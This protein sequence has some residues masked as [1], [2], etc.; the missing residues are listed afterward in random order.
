MYNA[1]QSYSHNDIDVEI[2][3]D[4]LS[5]WPKLFYLK[6]NKR[7]N[8]ISPT[9]D[10]K[11]FF[12][13][14]DMD[15]NELTEAIKTNLLNS[16]FLIVIISPSYLNS[17]W[18]RLE[19]EYFLEKEHNKKE[20]IFKIIK[21]PSQEPLPENLIGQLEYR[22]HNS[23]DDVSLEYYP[24]EQKYNVVLNQLAHKLVSLFSN[25]QSKDD[26]VLNTVFLN[27]NLSS[28][29]TSIAVHLENELKGKKVN[30]ISLNNTLTDQTL[31]KSQLKKELEKAS[32]SIHIVGRNNE[33]EDLLEIETAIEVSAQRKLYIKIFISSDIDTTSILYEK[34][35]NEDFVT[36]NMDVSI[37]IFEHFKQNVLDQIK[38]NQNG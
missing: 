34:L 15:L 26:S 18:C 9:L 11:I 10:Q 21:L 20:K 17:T 38:R 36:E 3:G 37:G 32:I 6:L 29:A 14:R 5:N 4:D 7:I 19:R 33:V 25:D 16:N 12:D 28:S 13:Q 8:Q 27:P 30:V 23:E 2:A 24:N 22:F 1:F 31:R 35:T